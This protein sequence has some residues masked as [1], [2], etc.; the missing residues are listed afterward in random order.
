MA[1]CEESLHYGVTFKLQLFQNG[2]N[3]VSIQRV[4][5]SQD[6]TMLYPTKDLNQQTIYLS[7]YKTMKELFT[8][9]PASLFY[10]PGVLCQTFCN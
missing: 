2:L 5:F 8:Y 4:W 7:C 1:I 6:V 3:P 9:V 10:V